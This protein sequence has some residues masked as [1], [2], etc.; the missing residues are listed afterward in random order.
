M[1]KNLKKY[2]SDASFINYSFWAITFTHLKKTKIFGCTVSVTDALTSATRDHG[3]CK[4]SETSLYIVQNNK[5]PVV[6]QKH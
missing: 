1:H 3:G 5:K 4:G 2:C 6:T